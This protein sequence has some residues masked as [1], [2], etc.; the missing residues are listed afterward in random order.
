[1][2]EIETAKY[3]QLIT[4]TQ[5]EIAVDPLVSQPATPPKRLFGNARLDYQIKSKRYAW[6]QQELDYFIYFHENI[7]PI[8]DEDQ[9]K[10]K[11]ATCKEFIEHAPDDVIKYFHEHHLEN[12][13]RVKTGYVTAMERKFGKKWKE[14]IN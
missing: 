12:S 11:Y 13:D 5:N 2:N 9:L 6:L 4:S 7:E 8:L 1:L 10:H 14:I 3:D